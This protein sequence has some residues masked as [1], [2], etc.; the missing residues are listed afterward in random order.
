MDIYDKFI[1]LMNIHYGKHGI[2]VIMKMYIENDMG[3]GYVKE[4]WNDRNVNISYNFIQAL[5]DCDEKYIHFFMQSDK[6]LRLAKKDFLNTS[7]RSWIK[8]NSP[9]IIT[10]GFEYPKVAELFIKIFNETKDEMF[11]SNETK[12]IFVF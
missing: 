4:A 10:I 2:S 6:F 5:S 12:D 3:L 9:R 7:I 8:D 1:K 11:L